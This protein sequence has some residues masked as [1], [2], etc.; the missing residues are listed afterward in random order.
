M[1]FNSNHLADRAGGR[2][3]ARVSRCAGWLTNYKS[4]AVTFLFT[5]EAVDGM[6]GSS[7][8][9]FG[10][11]AERAPAPHYPATP[12]PAESRSEPRLTKA[13]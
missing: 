7:V 4:G 10:R 1:P 6:P 8:G 11:V 3:S 13:P 12:P 9:G 5:R 2:C